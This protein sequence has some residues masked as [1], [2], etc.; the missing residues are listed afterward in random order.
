ML[1][2]SKYAYRNQ[3]PSPSLTRIH[4]YL[5]GQGSMQV[6][7]D[8]LG[9]CRRNL[10]ERDGTGVYRRSELNR[11]DVELPDSGFAASLPLCQS[12]GDLT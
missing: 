7:A 2:T 5:G 8:N 3:A 6:H 10:T 4:Y 1:R 9:I 11:G 12:L